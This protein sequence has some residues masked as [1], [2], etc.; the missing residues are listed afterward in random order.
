LNGLILEIIEFRY[1]LLRE[2]QFVSHLKVNGD[3][4]KGL[5]FW[6]TAN[7]QTWA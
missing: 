3:K 4:V 7:P 1:S 6:M 2:K 5:T